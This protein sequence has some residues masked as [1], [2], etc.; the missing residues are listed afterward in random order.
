M[1]FVMNTSASHEN[2]KF[3]RT[4]GQ[5]DGGQ[6]P[7]RWRVLL[8]TFGYWRMQLVWCLLVIAVLGLVDQLLL[9]N[10]MTIGVINSTDFGGVSAEPVDIA[11]L[12]KTGL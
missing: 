1:I 6:R 8:I 2:R 12:N 3:R 10:K 7:W 4:D 9:P 5:E 11:K